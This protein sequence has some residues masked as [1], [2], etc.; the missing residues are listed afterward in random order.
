[1]P[2]KSIE[3]IANKYNNVFISFFTD[4]EV[5]RTIIETHMG[6][7]KYDEKSKKYDEAMKK[8]V[9]IPYVQLRDLQRFIDKR[10]LENSNSETFNNDYKDIINLTHRL[11]L[12]YNNIYR[13]YFQELYNDILEKYP[14]ILHNVNL[15][16]FDNT[17]NVEDIF[18][19]LKE[20]IEENFKKY[21]K[22]LIDYFKIKK[23]FKQIEKTEKFAM[24]K[25]FMET[26]TF[27]QNKRDANG[28]VIDTEII[29]TPTTYIRN[30]INK[31]SN[32]IERYHYVYIPVLRMENSEKLMIAVAHEVA[33]GIKGIVKN[34]S[35]SSG[36]AR[37]KMGNS[38]KQKMGNIY[39][40]NIYNQFEEFPHHYMTRISMGMNDDKKRVMLNKKW[41]QLCEE[42]MIPSTLFIGDAVPRYYEV[43]DSI[44]S[45]F[46]EKLR[47]LIQSLNSGEI[48]REQFSK[49]IG[50]D[51]KTK[52]L[53]QLLVESMQNKSQGINEILKMISENN[54]NL[55]SIINDEHMQERIRQAN[56]KSQK[57]QTDAIS[58]ID[59][60]SEQ[61][62]KNKQKYIKNLTKRTKASV[63]SKIGER[64]FGFLKKTKSGT[65]V[66]NEEEHSL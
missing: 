27:Y 21:P 66:K 52:R 37:Y 59:E 15:H 24:D 10:K 44:S 18:K 30:S 46:V 51:I 2:I 41:N 28:A 6:T 20:I 39:G 25:A 53:A 16:D 13:K 19:K 45:E 50:G 56:E 61:F 54:G 26:S 58:E 34:N 62:E 9:F 49:Y 1:M 14:K 29:N 64:V 57:L 63:I 3:D 17:E 47:N 43:N 36:F 5:K 31:T 4:E 11:T 35:Y 33:H 48:T 7:D 22:R 42:N 55:Q 23:I 60:M 12:K 38:K 32:G 65:S 8:I 40:T